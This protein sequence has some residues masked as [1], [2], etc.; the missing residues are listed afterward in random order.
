[1]NELEMAVFATKMI[2]CLMSDNKKILAIKLIRYLYNGSLKESKDLVDLFHPKITNT[3]TPMCSHC[4]L[5]WGSYSGSF[6]DVPHETKED[7]KRHIRSCEANPLVTINNNLAK[8][9][10]ELTGAPE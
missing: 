6:D 5:T 4:G 2:Q 10:R 7:V 8:R 3:T 9:I 1:M